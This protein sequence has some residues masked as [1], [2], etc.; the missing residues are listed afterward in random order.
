MPQSFSNA[1]EWHENAM[2]SIV[3]RGWFCGPVLL[4]VCAV[5][6]MNNWI[7]AQ[8]ASGAFYAAGIGRGARLQTNENVRGDKIL[9]LD[10]NSADSL[11]QDIH[12]WMNDI[13]RAMNAGL[14][15]GLVDFEGHFAIYPP[16]SFYRRHIDAFRDDDAR[17]ITFIVYLNEKWTAADGG[18]L[19]LHISNEESIDIEPRGGTIVLFRS[20]DFEHEVLP[21]HTERRSLTGWFRVAP[22]PKR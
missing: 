14:F 15:T 16:G 17:S 11:M 13:R 1:G 19:R 6:K 10:A 20:R 9:W 12:G 4:D 21:A 18:Q 7:D 5:R 8:V 3:S 2:N 22:Y